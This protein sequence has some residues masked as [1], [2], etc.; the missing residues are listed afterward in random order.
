[1][2]FNES[3]IEELVKIS[4]RLSEKGFGTSTSGNCSVRDSNFAYLTPT[5]VALGDVNKGNISVTDFKGKHLAGPLPTKEQG[6]HLLIYSKRDSA[7][8]ILHVHPVYSIALSINL[9][10]RGI[11]VSPAATPQFVM[12]CGRVPVMPYAHPGSSELIENLNKTELDKAV[13]MANHGVLVFG[14]TAAL[15]MN[16]LEELEENSRIIMLSGLDEKM[17]SEKKINEL[18]E[19]KM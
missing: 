4:N 19:R 15:A 6:L 10:G 18:L 7:E 16:T 5:G 14:K 8:C 17:L 11:T 3:K 13:I 1:M 12:R 9:A 2:E